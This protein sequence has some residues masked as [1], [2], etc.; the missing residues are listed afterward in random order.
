MTYNF[1]F[2]LSLSNEGHLNSGSLISLE[3]SYWFII[4][5]LSLNILCGIRFTLSDD[6]IAVLDFSWLFLG[7][8][9][10][11]LLSTLLCHYVLGMSLINSI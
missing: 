10:V 4:A 5:F 9:S 2:I 1:F 6:N 7:V 3:I 8:S 11:L